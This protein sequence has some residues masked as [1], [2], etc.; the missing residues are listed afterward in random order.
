MG[1]TPHSL[2]H[3]QIEFYLSCVVTSAGNLYQRRSVLCS[4]VT[5]QFAALL[6]L[7]PSL[8]THRRICHCRSK[9]QGVSSTVD[10]QFDRKGVSV[11]LR[12]GQ[13]ERRAPRRQISGGSYLGQ[14]NI[15]YVRYLTSALAFATLRSRN[16]SK[17]PFSDFPN[18]VKNKFQ[19]VRIN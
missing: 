7:H 15:Y 10:K 16:S 18:D 6:T 13:E 12:C 9:Y 19:Y 14:R 5:T 17:C 3:L 8:K 11:R 2:G 4:Q 1:S